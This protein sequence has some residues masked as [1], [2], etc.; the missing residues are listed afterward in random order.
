[1]LT[2]VTV[3][4]P[5]EAAVAW[6]RPVLTMFGVEAPAPISTAVLLASLATEAIVPLL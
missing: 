4:S 6:M 5:L 1:M 3:C 2:P